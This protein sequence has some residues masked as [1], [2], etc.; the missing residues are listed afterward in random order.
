MTFTQQVAAQV[1]PAVAT[2]ASTA[3]LALIGV[4]GKWLVDHTKNLQVK[5]IEGR[6]CAAAD[7]SV[8]DVSNTMVE[9]L[10]K[11]GGGALSPAARERLRAEALAKLKTSL[12]GITVDSIRSTLGFASD[13]DAIAFLNTQVESAVWRMKIQESA[14]AAAPPAAPVVAKPPTA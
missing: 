4:A 7:A 3:L 6:V 10:R 1:L 9:D 5:A 2:V 13:A 14:A 11:E 8:R 12:G